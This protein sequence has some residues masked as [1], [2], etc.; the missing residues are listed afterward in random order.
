MGLTLVDNNVLFDVLERDR[1]WFGWSSKALSE[2]IDRG[3]A[4]INQVIYAEVSIGFSSIENLTETL[5]EAGLLRLD[6]PWE[7]GFLAGKSFRKYKRSGGLRRSPLP[8]FFIGA[9]AAVGGMALL[10][11]D[12]SRY[13]TYF[14]RLEIIAPE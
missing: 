6:L 4:A 1:A 14:P 2:A 3:G 11:R 10:T 5:D 12:P 7:A 8:D 9:H 13:R